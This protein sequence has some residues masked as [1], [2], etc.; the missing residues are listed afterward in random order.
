MRC[1]FFFNYHILEHINEGFG[2]TCF[3]FFVLNTVNQ[4]YI[5]YIQIMFYIL[6]QSWRDSVGSFGR[7]QSLMQQIDEI[8]RLVDPLLLCDFPELS[9]VAPSDP[10]P[11]APCPQADSVSVCI[12]DCTYQRLCAVAIWIL[13]NVSPV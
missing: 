8:S 2:V 11:A 9:S 13:H 1:F 4:L 12:D 10:R 6:L 7:D 3:V 5:S